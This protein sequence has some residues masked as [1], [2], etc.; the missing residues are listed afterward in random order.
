[1][2]KKILYKDILA[3]L[4]QSKG[5]FFSILCLMLIGSFCLVGL[6]MAEPDIH[7]TINYYLNKLNNADMSI[8]SNYG[9]SD[10]DQQELLAI[11]NTT[12][13]FGYFTDTLLNDKI[14]VRVF[15]NSKE[16]SKFELIEGSFPE[17][18]NQI[19]LTSVLKNEYQIGEIIQLSEKTTTSQLNNHQFVVT[20]F[21][22]SGELLSKTNLGTSTIG[23]GK[24][25]G[26]GVVTT[27][28]FENS[29]YTIARLQFDEA[30]NYGTF[31]KDYAK[32]LAHRQQEIET[33]LADNGEKRLHDL[34]KIA[35]VHIN[36]VQEQLEFQKEQELN[37]AE[38]NNLLDLQK[39]EKQ[40]VN[41][42]KELAY[43]EVPTYNIY[44]RSTMP[45]SQGYQSLK[46]TSEGISAVSNLFPTV[47]YVI[48]AL[49]TLTTMTRF[50]IEER[51]NAGILKA[52]GYTN[53][54]ILKKFAYYGLSSGFIGALIGTLAGMYVLPS[55]LG[56]TLLS[57]LILPPITLLFHVKI[58]IIAI[59]LSLL[60]SVFPAI[61]IAQ[62][63]LRENVTKLLVPKPPASGSA[64]LLEKIPFLWKR[65]NFSKKVTARNLFR[66]KQRMIMTVFGIA[67]SVALLFAGLGILSSLNG[68][69]QRQYEDIIRYDA[70]IIL[71]KTFS[72]TE[73]QLIDSQLQDPSIKGSLPIYVEMFQKKIEGI[74]DEQTITLLSP[75]HSSFD[76]Y[77]H[78]FDNNTGKPLTLNSNGI[79][80]SKKL[81]AIQ[82]LTVGDYLTLQQNGKTISL[83]I[84]G[85][86]E[87]YAG[88]FVFLSN[89]AYQH[90]F[91]HSIENNAYLL[92]LT[93]NSTDLLEQISSRF[94]QMSSIQSIIQNTGMIQLIHTII[95]SLRYVMLI[96]IIISLLLAIVILYNLTTINISERMR[97]LSTIKVLGFLN[98]EITVYIFREIGLLSIFG[99]LIGLIG[100]KLLHTLIIEMVATPVMMFNPHIPLWVAIVPCVL[101]TLL[102]II[103]GILVNHKLKKVDMLDALKSVD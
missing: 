48:A 75:Q 30:R 83:P 44:T 13:E 12:I 3:S 60:C 9:L 22:N 19:A 8:I 91:N 86:A 49:V 39:A 46:A 80:I 26:F 61:W 69:I 71:K 2:N 64:I 103:L 5:R 35:N 93:S 81:A 76:E 58:S 16:L 97:E 38:K 78:L 18:S 40:I 47:L 10:D 56:A 55:I 96:L 37:S 53:R 25:E 51:T 45:G 57:D 87:M 36:N 52:L 100:G 42:E 67:G 54:D 95:H 21:V 50:V 1:M 73:Q 11:P 77:I 101:I 33:L 88:H 79:I 4:F 59:L 68:M 62:Q 29:V 34:Q 70:M 94:L 63:E 15:S 7:N 74:D 98:N 99:I 41:T 82:H 14:A 6:K 32:I 85:I 89:E 23:N 66:Y 72:E 31:S 43:L 90:F 84:D 24:L 65:M 28:T 27:E 20:G 102:L 92:Q 17:N